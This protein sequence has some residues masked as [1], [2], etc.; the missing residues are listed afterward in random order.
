MIITLFDRLAARLD[1]LRQQR[2]PALLAEAGDD[3]D[4]AILAADRLMGHLSAHAVEPGRLGQVSRTAIGD[5]R[6]AN[7]DL[8]AHLAVSSPACAKPTPSTCSR[9]RHITS[10]RGCHPPSDAT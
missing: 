1:S 3:V 4:A 5:L 9:R 8:A 2:T 6:Y 7:E 10:R